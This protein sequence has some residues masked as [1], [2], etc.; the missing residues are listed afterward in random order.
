MVRAHTTSCVGI[1]SCRDELNR[2]IT[3]RQFS[4]G[5]IYF[6]AK[7]QILKR[8]VGWAWESVLCTLVQSYPCLKLIHLQW[9]YLHIRIEIV[10]FTYTYWLKLIIWCPQG[11]QQALGNKHV[12]L[13]LRSTFKK[14]VSM[15][16]ATS[17]ALIKDF[18]DSTC[19]NVEA[20]TLNPNAKCAFFSF[21]KCL[22]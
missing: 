13:D 5:L 14:I 2:K 8:N 20:H 16:L 19:T 1:K 9:F 15:H 3:W 21:A 18:M 22:S 10:L 7:G 6:L 12:L 17:F 4:T 11:P